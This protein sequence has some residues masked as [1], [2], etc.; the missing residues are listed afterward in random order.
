MI[1][2]GDC[3]KGELRCSKRAARAAWVRPGQTR[4]MLADE[5]RAARGHEFVDAESVAQVPPTARYGPPMLF[6]AFPRTVLF[7][8]VSM[9][10]RL[11]SAI[12]LRL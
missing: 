10:A 3:Q 5:L 4:R 8:R 1:I 6:V 2:Q 9:T 11:Y 12:P 7:D